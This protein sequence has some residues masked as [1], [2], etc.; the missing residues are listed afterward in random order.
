MNVQHI[1]QALEAQRN[2]FLNQN[3][4]LTVKVLELSEKIVELEAK[5]QGP[6]KEG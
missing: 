2:T 1:I 3:V 6:K 5:L 4:E